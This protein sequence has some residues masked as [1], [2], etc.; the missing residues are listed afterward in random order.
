M[1]LTRLGKDEVTL[2]DWNILVIGTSHDDE[3][4]YFIGY[5]DKDRLGRLSTEIQEMDES[6]MTGRTKS[7]STYSLMGE[8]GMPHPDAIY[9]L[10]QL[11]GE[12]LVA[13]ELFSEHATGALR[14]RYPLGVVNQDTAGV[15]LEQFIKTKK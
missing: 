15:T 2:M 10:E 5:S 7:G 6:T 14:F 9:V 8:P 3:T 13:R 1:A 12:A 11:L 4:A